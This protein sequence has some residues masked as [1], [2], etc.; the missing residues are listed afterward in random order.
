MFFKLIS[1]SKNRYII[2]NYKIRGCITSFSGG[3][4]MVVD[5]KSRKN[6]VLDSYEQLEKRVSDLQAY[7]N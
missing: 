3:D 4:K 6:E 1:K 7:A 5:Y 2:Y